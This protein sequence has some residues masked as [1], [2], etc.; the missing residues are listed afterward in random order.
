VAEIEAEQALVAA[1]GE[2]ITRF[3]KKIQATLARVGGKRGQVLRRGKSLPPPTPPKIG[4]EIKDNFCFRRGI[5]SERH[6][7]LDGALTTSS[8]LRL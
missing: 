5:F 1:K 4:G 6:F 8:A 2:L 7:I 3:E